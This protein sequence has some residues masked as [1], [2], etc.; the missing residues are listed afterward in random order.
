LTKHEDLPNYTIAQFINNGRP[1]QGTTKA[2]VYDALYKEYQS[3]VMRSDNALFTESMEG[4]SRGNEEKEKEKEITDGLGLNSD[5]LHQFDNLEI[6]A[7]KEERG[8]EREEK[9]TDINPINQDNSISADTSIQCSLP[10]FYSNPSTAFITAPKPILNIVTWN[11]RQL[12]FYL[13]SQKL[14][15]VAEVLMSFELIFLQEIPT[16]KSGEQRLIKL[17]NH[18]NGL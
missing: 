2:I 14:L 5:L 4:K 16:G 9:T 7:A 10:Q 8:G 11:C 17:I 15:K 1:V 12:R 3:E 18:M 6:N 13:D